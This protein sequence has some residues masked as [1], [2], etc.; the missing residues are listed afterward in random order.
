MK[1][2]INHDNNDLW[3]LYSKEQIEIG[4]RYVEIVEDYYGDA[5]IKTYRYEYLDMLIDEYII[6]YDEEPEIFGDDE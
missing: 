4:E 6:Q 3:C 2:K 1:I 5:L